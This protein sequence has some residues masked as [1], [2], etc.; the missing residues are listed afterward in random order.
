V[1]DVEPR[2]AG[3]RL[4]K[5]KTAPLEEERRSLDLRAGDYFGSVEIVQ[6]AA[7]Q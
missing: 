7:V 6:S 3:R 4:K 1:L 2:E 5:K